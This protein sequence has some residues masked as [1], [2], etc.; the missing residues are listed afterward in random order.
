[1]D[2]LIEGLIRLMG[3]P[4]DF[5]GPMNLGNS[6]EF[7]IIQLAKKILELTGSKSELLFKDLPIDDP[8]QRKPDVS[9]AEK[10][11]QWKP[12]TQID[13]GLD[14]TIHYFKQLFQ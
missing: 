10:M 8:S 2:D 5:T 4:D 1:V 13:E 11:I 12:Q 14:K 7:T 3:T 6:G 9:L